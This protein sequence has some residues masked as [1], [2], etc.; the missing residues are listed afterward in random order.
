MI[1]LT[2]PINKIALSRAMQTQ[3]RRRR[4]ALSLVVESTRHIEHK[5][6]LTA[7]VQ[8]LVAAIGNMYVRHH[9]TGMRF[10]GCA[11]V[12]DVDGLSAQSK[13][14][15]VFG[16]AD[17]AEDLFDDGCTDR[18]VLQ[19]LAECVQAG[20]VFVM[21]TRVVA[22]TRAAKA[23]APVEIPGHVGSVEATSVKETELCVGDGGTFFGELDDARS[24]FVSL[25]VKSLLEGVGR[26]GE[27]VAVSG[28]CNL[29]WTDVESDHFS[30]IEMR[31][32]AK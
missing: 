4:T 22:E 29:V 9:A 17:R 27:V 31:E 14:L 1:M 30:L 26:P 2:I 7:Q 32:V 18:L 23:A 12:D 21:L 8:H 15:R 20:K 16:K 3:V 5:S 10:L 13:A 19:A 6:R 11:A 28:K 25:L 24:A